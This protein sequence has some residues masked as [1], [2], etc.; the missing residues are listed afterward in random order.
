MPKTVY[1][2]DPQ[3]SAYAGTTIAD[4]DQMEEGALLMPAFTTQEDPP[5]VPDG[6]RAYWRGNMDGTPLA[7]R[8]WEVLR[9]EAVIPPPALQESDTDKYE[10]ARAIAQAELD[11]AARTLGFDNI[12]TA[13]TYAEEPAFPD[14]QV[15]GRRL[16]RLRSLVWMEATA[17]WQEVQGGAPWPDEATFLGRLPTYDEVVIM[18]EQGGT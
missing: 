4:D 15:L 17:M 2:W 9:M 1:S 16:R 12:L 13:V 6:H 14:L 5:Q 18:E 3:S 10:R 7:G 11:R 8:S